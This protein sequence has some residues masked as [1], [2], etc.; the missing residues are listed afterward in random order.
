MKKLALFVLAATLVL[1]QDIMDFIARF[2]PYGNDPVVD[3]RLS[4]G[5]TFE[6]DDRFM[7]RR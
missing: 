3:K 7:I 2:V 6:M 1:K 5:Y 4:Y